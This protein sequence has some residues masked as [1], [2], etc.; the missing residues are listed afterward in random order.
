M[1]TK[2][3]LEAEAAEFEETWQA[4]V[5]ID[6]VQEKIAGLEKALK[7]DTDTNEKALKAVGSSLN[8]SDIGEFKGADTGL[9]AIKRAAAE[10]KLKTL[11]TKLTGL[12]AKTYKPVK[13]PNPMVSNVVTRAMA[14]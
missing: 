7:A 14:G 6:T 2:A 1:A 3:E 4:G 12:K 5:L 9:G 10:D 8:P 11:K 13:I